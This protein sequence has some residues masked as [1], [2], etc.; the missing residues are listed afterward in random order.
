V[1]Y[2]LIVVSA[3]NPAAADTSVNA[4]CPSSWKSRAWY[5][6]FCPGLDPTAKTSSAPSLS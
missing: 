1:T 6:V 5:V 4:P 3:G 2:S